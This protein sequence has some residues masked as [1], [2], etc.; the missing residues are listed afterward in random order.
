MDL[1]RGVLLASTPLPLSVILL[2]SLSVILLTSLSIIMLTSLSVI[3][4]ASLSLA[5][6][7]H[8]PSGKY[9][10]TSLSLSQVFAYISLSLSQVFANLSLASSRLLLS[11]LFCLFL[12]RSRSNSRPQRPTSKP[13]PANNVRPSGRRLDD[14]RPFKSTRSDDQNEWGNSR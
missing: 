8:S 5:F 10:P 1:Q 12:A 7:Y 2:A 4:L 6:A 9:C 13:R 14:S 3:M 11:L